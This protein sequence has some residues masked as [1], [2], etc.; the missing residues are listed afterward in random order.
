MSDAPL[1]ITVNGAPRELPDGTTLGELLSA[2]GVDVEGVAVAINLE[3][4]PRGAIP[5]RALQSGDRVG[6]VRAVG[7]G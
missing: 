1:T 7:G 2:L 4:V 5:H 6:L 3:V